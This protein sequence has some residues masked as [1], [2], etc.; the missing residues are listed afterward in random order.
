MGDAF[1]YARPV[2]EAW[3]KNRVTPDGQWLL[4][5][6]NRLFPAPVSPGSTNRETPGFFRWLGSVCLAKRA[7]EHFSQQERKYPDERNLGLL[8]SVLS[9]ASAEMAD[10]IEMKQQRAIGAAADL[11][12]WR[13]V[14]AVH[15]LEFVD[16]LTSEYLIPY[17]FV[18]RLNALLEEQPAG[19]GARRD[20]SP[21]M[22]AQ[23]GAVRGRFDTGVQ[24][25]P[26]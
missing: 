15:N 21:E 22:W 24:G 2:W 7:A 25:W 6:Y 12:R 13:S 18:Q 19:T 17:V 1:A 9:V 14:E 10:P 11:V 23:M 3:A 4:R 8:M 16:E 20:M 26:V 5:Q